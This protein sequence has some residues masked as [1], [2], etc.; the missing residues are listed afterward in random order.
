MFPAIGMPGLQGTYTT[1][2]NEKDAAY[3]RSLDFETDAL[4]GMA[5][6]E[7]HSKNTDINKYKNEHLKK[8]HSFIQRE[9]RE[10]KTKI[11]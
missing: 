4:P 3:L 7:H 1:S 10:P 5:S 6:K 2:Q 8:V 9:I 11:R